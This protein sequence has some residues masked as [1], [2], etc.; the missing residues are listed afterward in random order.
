MAYCNKKHIKTKLTYSVI[1]LFRYS[2]P[3]FRIPCF[4][5]SPKTLQTF[6]LHKFYG[7][8]HQNMK[9]K[10]CENLISNIFSSEKSAII[11]THYVYSYSH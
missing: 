9:I 4:L 6:L 7:K 3:L 2:I 5:E 8:Q 11:Y 10:A 1:P